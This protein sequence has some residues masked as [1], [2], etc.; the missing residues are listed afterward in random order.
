VC[1]G[2]GSFQIDLLAAIVFIEEASV[3]HT[4]EAVFWS[5]TE[6]M[7]NPIT[8]QLQPHQHPLKPPLTAQKIHTPFISD[9]NP[10]FAAPEDPN[11]TSSS[12]TQTAHC[13]SGLFDP[14]EFISVTSDDVARSPPPTDHP[15]SGLP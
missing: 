5:S 13:G 4:S 7:V 3:R 2:E 15:L 6:A 9:T 10:P 8:P 12:I 11:V 1:D 14:S